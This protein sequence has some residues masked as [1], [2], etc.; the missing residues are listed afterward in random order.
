[1]K[2]R[3]PSP[4]VLTRRERQVVGL[5]SRGLRGREV[6]EALCLAPKT[7]DVIRQSA[8]DKLGIHDRVRLA[9][10][11]HRHGLHTESPVIR[12]PSRPKAK[13]G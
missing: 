12:E 8:Y 11:A 10:W 9:L 2:E 7:I 13:R 3:D 5:L 6:A 4:G 1:M